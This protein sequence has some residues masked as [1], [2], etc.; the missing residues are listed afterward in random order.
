MRSDANEHMKNKRS[1]LK[2]TYEEAALYGYTRKNV[3][4]MRVREIKKRA[5]IKIAI[6]K[7]IA[8]HEAEILAARSLALQEAARQLEFA[9]EDEP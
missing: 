8:E 9:E 2:I 7:L 4:D 5:E 6:V 3:D 1:W